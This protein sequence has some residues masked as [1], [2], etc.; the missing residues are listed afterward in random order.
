M[1]K[2]ILFFVFYSNCSISIYFINNDQEAYMYCLEN[3]KSH[4]AILWPK[5]HGKDIE[6]ENIF[7]KYGLIKYKKIMSVTR[8]QAYTLFSLAHPKVTN[9][10]KHYKEYFSHHYEQPLRI[11]LVEFANLEITLDCKHEIRDLFDIGHVSIHIND[12]HEETL[13]LAQFFF[14]TTNNNI[15]IEKQKRSDYLTSPLSYIKELGICLFGFLK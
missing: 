3:K 8:D 7:N 6:L 5:A 4:V 9:L 1:K 14:I 11:F 12:H 15:D 2:I 13:E 10:A